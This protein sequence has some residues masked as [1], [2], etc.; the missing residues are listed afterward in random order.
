MQ[1]KNIFNRDS[2]KYKRVVYEE[3]TDSEPEAEEIQYTPQ[4]EPIEQEK[5]QKQ[6]QNKG[7]NKII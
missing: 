5:E 2:K 3:E 7:K 6:P 4:D 1:K